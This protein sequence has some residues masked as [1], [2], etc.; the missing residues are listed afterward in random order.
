MSLEQLCKPSGY[1]LSKVKDKM[2]NLGTEIN[3]REIDESA[4]LKKLVSGEA[5]LTREIYRSPEQ[6]KT[7]CKLAF[8]TNIMP[9]FRGGSDAEVR[10]MRILH[11]DRKPEVQDPS[12]GAKIKTEKEGVLNW[13]LE[14]LQI[15]FM[16]GGIPEG[17]KAAGA[18]KESFRVSND[19]VGAFVGERCRL[20]PADVILKRDLMDAFKEWCDETGHHAEKTENYFFKTL[21]QRYPA[22]TDSRPTIANRRE[23]CL[24]GIGLI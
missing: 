7:T 10:R 8:L 15:M 6:I 9:T 12:L 21:R 5:M 23:H 18:A 24:N 16:R 3:G 17:G 22:I 2:L 20:N 19:P 11:F 1:E 13:M 4:N 14:G